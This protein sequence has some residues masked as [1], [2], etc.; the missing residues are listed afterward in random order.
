MKPGV[1]G[2]GRFGAGLNPLPGNKY[3]QSA[4]TGD[5]GLSSQ[6]GM[7]GLSYS[8]AYAENLQKIQA[9]N[10][11]MQ[12]EALSRLQAERESLAARYPLD[13][14]L[15]GLGG[16]RYSAAEVAALARYQGADGLSRLHSADGLGRLS[17][18]TLARYSAAAGDSLSSR[19]SAE[20][21][22]SEFS[23]LQAAEAL[24]RIPADGLGR[25]LSSEGLGGR[26]P[27]SLNGSVPGSGLGGYLG[28]QE[29]AAAAYGASFSLAERRAAAAGD[30]P[31]SQFLNS[32]A[33]LLDAHKAAV[34]GGYPG[35]GGVSGGLS[36]MGGLLGGRP[37]VMG[38][39]GGG[40][41]TLEAAKAAMGAEMN[42]GG[43][44]SAAAL[45]RRGMA[46]AMGPPPFPGTAGPN[47]GALARSG[48][49]KT[50]SVNRDPNS[51]PGMIF[52]CNN[53]TKE[54][55]FR[56]AL[57]GLPAS[58]V[59]TVEKIA[60]GTKLF[61]FNF[62]TKELYGIFEAT[63]RGAMNIEPDA[64]ATSGFFPAQVRARLVEACVALHES[65]FKPAIQEN[66]FSDKKFN[67]IL[68][69]K[70]VEKLIELFRTAKE[71]G[72]AG[73]L[74]GSNSRAAKRSAAESIAGDSKKPIQ[75]RLGGRV[76]E[77]NG[78]KG[79]IDGLK[80]GV[81]K[82]KEA[83]SGESKEQQAEESNAGGT[84]AQQEENN[85]LGPRGR[86]RG[87]KGSRH[88][89]EL[90][91]AEEPVGDEPTSPDIPR[92]RFRRLTGKMQNGNL[93]GGSAAA[94]SKGASSAGEGARSKDHLSVHAGPVATQADAGN[95][96]V[97]Q[98]GRRSVLSR[99]GGRV[100]S[101]A[102]PGQ[103]SYSIHSDSTNPK[104]TANATNL[105]SKKPVNGAIKKHRDVGSVVDDDSFAGI[106]VSLADDFYLDGDDI[107]SDH[108]GVAY[109]VHCS[110]KLLRDR[111]LSIQ[112][113]LGLQ[114]ET[115]PEKQGRECGVCP[116]VEGEEALALCDLPQ[117]GQM[118]KGDKSGEY[119][120]QC[121]EEVRSGSSLKVS[122]TD[123][124]TEGHSD[125][126]VDKADDFVA[127]GDNRKDDGNG[128]VVKV[129]GAADGFSGLQSN[130]DCV[131][132][133]VKVGDGNCDVDVLQAAGSLP[134]GDDSM[135]EGGLPVVG[136]LLHGGGCHY[137]SGGVLSGQANTEGVVPWTASLGADITAAAAA[138]V[139]Q[140]NDSLDD[141][142]TGWI[143]RMV[144]GD[145]SHKGAKEMPAVPSCT[146]TE[147]VICVTEPLK[148]AGRPCWSPLEEDVG[149]PS[150]AAG[151]DDDVLSPNDGGV[152]GKVAR[153]VM[154]AA[155]SCGRIGYLSEVEGPG[156][157]SPVSKL[158]DMEC[159]GSGSPKLKL[160][161]GHLEGDG[162]MGTMPCEQGKGASD[163]DA[164]T[165]EEEANDCESAK[166]SEQAGARTLLENRV[167][168]LPGAGVKENELEPSFEEE[169]KESGKKAAGRGKEGAQS[170][171]EGKTVSKPMLPIDV[172]AQGTA[173]PEAGDDNNEATNGQK[174]GT[175]SV[176][177]KR[178][179]G[180]VSRGG[181]GRGDIWKNPSG[182]VVRGG[183]ISSAGRGR[184]RMRGQ[185]SL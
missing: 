16:G 25:R 167:L 44:G 23:R 37:Q 125:F 1:V 58:N 107:G 26:L 170:T 150:P 5:A 7:N 143:D 85:E 3:Y 115:E 184:G 10:R 148:G 22:L 152:V 149:T 98:E 24:N 169:E 67:Y 86:R 172:I 161:S 18:E 72:G 47:S 54:E 13:A 80:A 66:Y 30:L 8:E 12:L 42:L 155:G 49:P 81:D 31:G 92:G 65:E 146:E 142:G 123:G 11:R 6:L 17:S 99:L 112:N 166:S 52:G 19:L 111:G 101:P 2:S 50:E 77:G 32:K 70:Q 71:K 51:L 181:R 160:P 144:A 68:N 153:T 14:T 33:G 40:Y 131:R 100:G 147:D 62:G 39:G 83:G 63:C 94:A 164:G 95:S 89:R 118:N 165:W 46:A 119:A 168:K 106:G 55:C 121:D 93:V 102:K 179:Q 145:V 78:V 162:C 61:L 141:M 185:G 104:G 157:G 36:S 158:P 120:C 73:A 182:W 174:D 113:V 76:K 84:S 134:A 4:G 103:V 127:A 45:A 175:S 135:L 97:N 137:Q 35:A 105:G 20:A 28:A 43:A 140:I 138:D 27:P 183:R 82:S 41:P 154:S 130:V 74:P 122:H 151:A 15:G 126:P 108:E 129:G 176:S 173:T 53:R 109:S 177:G 56:R 88:S 133:D 75:A 139:V 159:A 116:S 9:E 34:T 79:G 156:R 64:F 90:A 110:R 96:V 163:G 38:Y 69:E 21:R 136:G 128:L 178:V 87:R 124:N 114:Q 29:D 117:R 132:L 60:P 48:P 171:D 59:A 180:R 91:S 57:F